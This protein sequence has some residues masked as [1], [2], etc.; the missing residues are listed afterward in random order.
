MSITFL[1]SA[2][3]DHFG[4]IIETVVITSDFVGREESIAPLEINF[5]IHYIMPTLRV[6]FEGRSE[7]L[8]LARNRIT[9]VRLR[10]NKFGEYS[11]EVG[12]GDGNPR[13]SVSVE[14]KGKMTSFTSNITLTDDSFSSIKL[15]RKGISHS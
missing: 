11:L 12:L 8:A 13:M 9:V 14:T 1:I 4:D 10:A 5:K 15:R 3:S 7:S 2:H 6:R